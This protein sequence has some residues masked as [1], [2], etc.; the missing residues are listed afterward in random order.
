MITKNKIAATKSFLVLATL[1]IE[2]SRISTLY[3]LTT[4]G[5][6]T[7]AMCAGALVASSIG[8][9]SLPMVSPTIAQTHAAIAMRGLMTANIRHNASLP[10]HKCCV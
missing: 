7:V 9:S 10:M 3:F 2:H 5:C 1:T 8:C 6:V 4:V